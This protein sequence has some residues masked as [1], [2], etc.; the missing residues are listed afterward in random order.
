MRAHGAGGE[1]TAQAQSRVPAADESDGLAHAH[2][3]GVGE[4]AGQAVVGGGEPPS[5]LDLL[6]SEDHAVGVVVFGDDGQRRARGRSGG[7]GRSDRVGRKARRLPLVGPGRDDVVADGRGLQAQVAGGVE[8]AGHGHEDAV[9]QVERHS[10]AA[11]SAGRPARLADGGQSGEGAGFQGGATRER[12][13]RAQDTRIV[14]SASAP[15]QRR[16]QGGGG[17]GHGAQVVGVVEA[18]GQ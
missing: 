7:V 18:V 6:A 12:V 1:Q 4:P 3:R 15:G 14:E 13:E 5:G 8:V 2:R 11:T 10:A 17:Y 16:H 9:G